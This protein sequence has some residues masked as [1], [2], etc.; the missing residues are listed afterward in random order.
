MIGPGCIEKRCITQLHIHLLRKGCS[1]IFIV[2]SKL[3]ICKC[4]IVIYNF[5]TFALLSEFRIR[6]ILTGGSYGNRS[7]WKSILIQNVKTGNLSTML[8][9]IGFLNNRENNIIFWG[10][11]KPVVNL[12]PYESY[13][14]LY[15]M[16][17]S[18]YTRKLLFQQIVAI[19]FSSSYF[20]WKCSV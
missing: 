4:V 17:K 18:L 15:H 10:I 5:T 16:N 20:S 7:I 11:Q 6:Q 8:L 1:Y 19:S 12:T 3:S 13:V 9:V 14:F 2:F